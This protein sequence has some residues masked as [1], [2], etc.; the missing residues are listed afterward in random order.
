MTALA[1][2]GDSI[3]LEGG[4]STFN[5]TAHIAKIV[6][7]IGIVR[8]CGRIIVETVISVIGMFFFEGVHNGLF[9]INKPLEKKPFLVG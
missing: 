6:T 5:N 2:G 4:K 7:G 1:A 3:G 9:N 8:V